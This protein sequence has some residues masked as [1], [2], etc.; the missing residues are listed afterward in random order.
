MSAATPPVISSA[1]LPK[2][3]T[4]VKKDT[5]EKNINEINNFIRHH[6]NLAQARDVYENLVNVLD[7]LDVAF[8]LFTMGIGSKI[9]SLIKLC[10]DKTTETIREASEEKVIIGLLKLLDYNAP[11]GSTDEELKEANSF[12]AEM[13]KLI[14]KGDP[15]TI[16]LFEGRKID[17]DPV[18]SKGTLIN[19]IVRN[20]AFVQLARLIEAGATLNTNTATTTQGS[21]VSISAYVDSVLPGWLDKTAQ[22]DIIQNSAIVQKTGPRREYLEALTKKTQNAQLPRLVDLPVIVAPVMPLRLVNAADST[23]AVASAFNA[24][25]ITVIHDSP[26]T[27]RRLPPPSMEVELTPMDADLRRRREIRSN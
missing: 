15:A 5:R 22:W 12:R 20:D 21:R 7:H 2:K 10:Y 25:T 18:L 11:P 9:F 1:T 17:S 27:A 26:P 23:A 19:R 6:Q 16:L 13:L 3:D 8:G 4:N 14:F 24:P